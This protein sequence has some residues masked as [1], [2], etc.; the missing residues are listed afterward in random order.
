M[1]TNRRLCPV[2]RIGVLSE[3]RSACLF[4]GRRTKAFKFKRR[5]WP[6]PPKRDYIPLGEWAKEQ[7]LKQYTKITQEQTKNNPFLIVHDELLLEEIEK[8]RISPNETKGLPD[9]ANPTE[10]EIMPLPEAFTETLR[11]EAKNIRS[12]HKAM[13][14][15]SEMIGRGALFEVES[16]FCHHKITITI[17]NPYGEDRYTFIVDDTDTIKGFCRAIDTA[18]EWFKGAIK[19]RGF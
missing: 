14:L 12:I 7:R 13:K 9:E 1:S 11:E 10:E 15:Y 19:E 5:P 2:C 8:K 18:H 6:E 4:C 3:N 17:E 16:R